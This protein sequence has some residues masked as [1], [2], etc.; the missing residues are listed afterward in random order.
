MQDARTF[1]KPCWVQ[2]RAGTN[3]VV[4]PLKTT[5]GKIDTGQVVIIDVRLENPHPF[6]V[7][8]ERTQFTLT[9]LGREAYHPETT[10]TQ[11]PLIKMPANGVLDKVAL[12]YAVP[13]DFFA[14]PLVLQ[15]G[16]DSIV[17]KDERPFERRLANGEFLT[18]RRR[19][20]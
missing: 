7:G 12:S 20:W 10:G 16:A 14:G 8:L 4:Q 1:G 15:I 2:T 11:T 13:D 17:I 18:F 19:H 3:F 6:E 9:G 5:I